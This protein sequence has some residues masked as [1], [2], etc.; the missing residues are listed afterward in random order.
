[1][2]RGP[3][4]ALIAAVLCAAVL[5]GCGLGPGPGTSNA[6]VTVTENFGART[7]GSAIEARVPGSETVMGLLEGHFRITT[8]YGGGFVESIDGHSGT[9]QH[10][11]W[12]YYVNGVQASKGAAVT[13]VHEGDRIWWDLHDWV[14]AESIPAVVGSFPEPFVHGIGGKRY[15][16]VLECGSGLQATC[17]RLGAELHHD[18]VPVADQLLGTGSGSDSLAI[19]VAPFNQ[20]RGTI[21]ADLIQAG[22]RSSGVYARFADGGARLAL[23]DPLGQTVRVL[24]PGAGLVAA[25]QDQYSKPEWLITGTDA[26]G[27]RAAAAALTPARLHDRFALAVAGSQYLPLPLDPGM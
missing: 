6:T 22:P 16:T 23:L 11:D 7:L 26:A 12:F 13:D 27:V 1:L 4:P 3:L 8:R 18:G 24:G 20:L 19:A 10:Y 14:A 15:P 25:T 5:A 21:A 2:G 17:E 9:S